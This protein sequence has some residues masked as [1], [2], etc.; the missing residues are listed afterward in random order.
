M[1]VSCRSTKEINL[2][3][4]HSPETVDKQKQEEH[5][6]EMMS[7]PKRLIW[8]APTKQQQKTKVQD[9]WGNIDTLKSNVF[10]ITS[11]QGGKNL[12]IQTDHELSSKEG[13]ITSQQ[14]LML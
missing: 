10:N 3:L 1:H 8:G 4:Q 14:L 6:K 9:S 2:S 7:I 11:K 5:D 13:F 12:K